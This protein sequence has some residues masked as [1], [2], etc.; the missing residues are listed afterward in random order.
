MCNISDNLKVKI[1]HQ[2]PDLNHLF[3]VLKRSNLTWSLGE[4]IKHQNNLDVPSQNL[5]IVIVLPFKIIQK[6]FHIELMIFI[7]QHCKFVKGNEEQQMSISNLELELN[8]QLCFL[9][10]TRDN[11]PLHTFV[12]YKLASQQP[13]NSCRNT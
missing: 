12:S 6:S 3:L 11:K 13:V 9:P 5:K 10:L 2:E 4:Q 7:W 8:Y 1:F